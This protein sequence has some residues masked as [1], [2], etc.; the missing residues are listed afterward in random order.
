MS[1]PEWMK[2]GACHD[3]DYDPELW[4]GKDMGSIN[5]AKRVCNT[6]CPVREK[7]FEYAVNFPVTL[8]GVWG[9]SAAR[10]IA[11]ERQRRALQVTDERKL[12]GLP[13]EITAE[14]EP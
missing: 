9:G 6:K 7:C 11:S 8:V 3:G 12:S 4:F 1:Q 2:S 10:G 5:T 13:C 14:E